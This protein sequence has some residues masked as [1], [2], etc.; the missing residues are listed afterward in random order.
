CERYR[1]FGGARLPEDTLT[2]VHEI[3][4]RAKEGDEAARKAL[5][6]TALHLG[7]GIANMVW[8]LDAD[9][10]VVD[11][12]ITRAWQFIAPILRARLPDAYQASGIP[13]IL[14]PSVLGGDAGV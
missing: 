12:A 5:H 7:T 6:E 4:Q 3:A 1:A 14:R 8:G 11:G 2:A 10:V 9:V 13:V